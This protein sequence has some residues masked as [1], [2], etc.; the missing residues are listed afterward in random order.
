MS[1]PNPYGLNRCQ[2]LAF[3][4]V[5]ENNGHNIFL[6][7]PAGT[8][9]SYTLRSIIHY[10]KAV[11]NKNVG[12]TASTGNAALQIGATTLHSFLGIGLGKEEACVLAENAHQKKIQDL[13]KLDMLIIDEISMIAADLLSKI[14]EY[15]CIIRE[16]QRP[17]GGLQVVL[18]GDFCQLGP[19]EGVYCFLSPIWSIS[20]IITVQ[21]EEAM[22]HSE[23]D[24]L[25]N[26]LQ[27]VRWG[28]IDEQ[29]LNLLKSVRHTR[30]PDGIVPTIL[31]ANNRE[32]ETINKTKYQQ[33]VS[34]GA[35]SKTF[36]PTWSKENSRI[37]LEWM[38]RTWIPNELE[39][40]VGCQVLL[41]H[42]LD[43]SSGLVNGSRG[44]VLSLDSEL[45]LVKFANGVEK[46]IVSIRREIKTSL[47][48]PQNLA[49]GSKV[50]LL[51][52]FQNQN[53]SIIPCGTEGKIK[54]MSIDARVDAIACVKFNILFAQEVPIKLDLLRG[55]N[56]NSRGGDSWVQY[57]PLRLAYALTV[58]RS[59]GMT[60]DAAVINLNRQIFAPGQAYTA[61]SRVK[62]LDC[63]RVM[64]V[65]RDVFQTD[66]N[67]LRFYNHN[68]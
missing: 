54:R 16:D 17:F 19:V 4:T 40:C 5:F 31:L 37:A 66:E 28:I 53:G 3:D 12:V 8:G 13:K 21:L 38:K 59:Q 51:Q 58:H 65:S 36:K 22:R 64:N 23:D 60:L 48:N 45:P 56:V 68:M 43:C 7:G 10:A 33:L 24:R 25:L 26:I 42:N 44:V 35:L 47:T 11:L 61:L 6:T 20:E 2:Q 27:Q 14:S 49:R 67:V 63:L 32:V 34:S 30:F 39:L 18:C 9:K 29:S 57:I 50:F 55:V 41:T 15:L 46:Q 62:N 52:D 1:S